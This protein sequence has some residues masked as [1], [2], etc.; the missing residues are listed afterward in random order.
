MTDEMDY[1]LDELSVLTELPKRTIRY[2]IQMALVD[3]PIGEKRAARYS[4]QHLERLLTIRK[5]T[6]SGISLERIKELLIDDSET[7]P[8]P[9]RRVGSIEVRS[10]LLV[11][12]GIEVV[13]EPGQAN[14]SAK[15]LRAFLK[16]S[17]ELYN[18]IIEE[19]EK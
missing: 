2:Y 6:H 3:R 11:A 12:P 1:S 10:H 18:K 5:W 7:P 9:P 4:Q 16:S 13:V 17:I 15:Q 8:I 19:D 14:L